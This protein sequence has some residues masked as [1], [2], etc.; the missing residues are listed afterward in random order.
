M[1]IFWFLPLF[2]SPF[3]RVA[4]FFCVYRRKRCYWI[5]PL[6]RETIRKVKKLSKRKKKLQCCCLLNQIGSALQVKKRRKQKLQFLLST[7]KWSD[8]KCFHFSFFLFY[9]FLAYV[10]RQAIFFHN[11]IMNSSSSSPHNLKEI[12][13]I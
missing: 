8:I 13:Q 11:F 4:F 6:P 2:L 10:K 12:S 1:E 7:M 5:L 9:F 3:C